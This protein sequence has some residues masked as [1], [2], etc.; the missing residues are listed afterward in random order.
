L[1][2]LTEGWTFLESPRWHA[3]RFW[4]SDFY[5]GDVIAV[6]LDGRVEVVTHVDAQPS[7]LGWLPDG[8]LLVVSMRDRKVLR[9]ANGATTEHA[10]LRDIA[11]GHC[12][13]M[14]VCADGSAYV[15]NFG[16]DLMNGD[17][18]RP[19]TLALVESGGAVRAAA[20]EM[21]FPNGMVIDPATRTLIVAET[22][23]R[24]LTACTVAS[25]GALTGRRIWAS[26][27]RVSPDGLALDA[28]GCVWV[29][30]AMHGRAVRVR[31]GGEIVDE[32]THLGD[33]IFACALGG[34]AG[35]TLALC[36]AAS[37]REEIARGTRSSRLVVCEVD[38]PHAGLP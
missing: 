9:V 32:R 29:A 38:V 23:A 13:D 8:D 36:T 27:E 1:R 37:F 24:R 31:A 28:E 33:G 25:D 18:L 35:K 14:I 5:S 17:A 16:F 34:D 30:D 19:A 11:T 7:G 6:D 22:L 26:V 4:A 21:M 12:N 20:G 10:D 15:G 2:V 3:G